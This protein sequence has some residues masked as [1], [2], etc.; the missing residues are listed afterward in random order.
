[1]RRI[2]DNIISNV[3][4]YAEPSEPV[5]LTISKK[6]EGI[7]IRQSNRIAKDRQTSENYKMGL[8]SIRRIAQN[9]GGTVE[10]RDENGKYEIMITLSNI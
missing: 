7:E 4:K 5:E 10:V 1:M 9:Y 8:Y 3:K 6:D 2:F